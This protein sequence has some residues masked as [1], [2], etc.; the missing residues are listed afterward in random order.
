VPHHLRRS[1]PHHL[2]RSTPHHLRRSTPHHLRRSTPHHLWRSTGTTTTGTTTTGT[3]TTGTTTTDR[4][5][6]EHGR[7]KSPRLRLERPLPLLRVHQVI[8]FHVGFMLVAAVMLSS[9][10]P[11][12][13]R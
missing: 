4:R 1:T 5:F 2:R 9:N 11:R 13:M 7:R 3:T 8:R 12:F 10:A 6:H